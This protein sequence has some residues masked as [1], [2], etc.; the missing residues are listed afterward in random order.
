MFVLSEGS[1][2]FSE[3]LE[4]P[5]GSPLIKHKVCFAMCLDVGGINDFHEFKRRKYE[6]LGSHSA[7]NQKQNLLLKADIFVF[8]IH[9]L[10]VGVFSILNSITDLKRS[11]SKQSDMTSIGSA[12]VCC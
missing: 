10:H 3:Y 4:G 6:I 5:D 1:R 11:V 9:V 7:S 2:V 12:I 8:S